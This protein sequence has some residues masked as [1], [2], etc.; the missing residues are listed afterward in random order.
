[1][2]DLRID[3]RPDLLGRVF[4]HVH[5]LL[6]DRLIALHHPHGMIIELAGLIPLLG[7]LP[8]VLGGLAIHEGLKDRVES[9]HD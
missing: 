3:E 2:G 1:M 6:K 5:V 4:V 8:P 9:E 7:F